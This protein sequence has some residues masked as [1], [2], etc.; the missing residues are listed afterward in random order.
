MIE[1]PK[2]INLI[3]NS[4]KWSKMTIIEDKS[5]QTIEILIEFI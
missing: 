3:R 5:G 1:V 4:S 2:T